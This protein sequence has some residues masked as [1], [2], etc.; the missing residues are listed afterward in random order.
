M[1]NGVRRVA[2]ADAHA[3]E[4]CLNRIHA[5]GYCPKPDSLRLAPH[6][7]HVSN[8]SQRLK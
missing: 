3:I 1:A 2:P 4:D 8:F 7:G 5:L 6:P